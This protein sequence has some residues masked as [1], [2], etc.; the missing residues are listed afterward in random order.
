MLDLYDLPLGMSIN[1]DVQ[2]YGASVGSTSDISFQIWNKP[3]GKSF[4]WLTCIGG[5]AGGG[6]GAVTLPAMARA[7]AEAAAVQASCVCF[8][9]C[10]PFRTSCTFSWGMAERGR[11]RG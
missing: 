4:L 9:P 2:Y 7:A 6:G 10:M 3:R 8:I 11:R 1:P 5:G